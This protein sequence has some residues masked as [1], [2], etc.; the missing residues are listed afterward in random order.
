MTSKLSKTMCETELA[1]SYYTDARALLAHDASYPSRSWK[2]IYSTATSSD[3]MSLH[4]V[5]M[6][7]V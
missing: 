5:A 3:M 4:T 6:C 2:N 7:E 1:L